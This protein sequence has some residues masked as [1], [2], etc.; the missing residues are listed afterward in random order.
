VLAATI[1]VATQAAEVTKEVVIATPELLARVVKV[2]ATTTMITT[3]V[4][5]LRVHQ[6]HLG[7]ST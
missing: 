3:L 1:A 7:K 2:E 4:R 5:K 6:E